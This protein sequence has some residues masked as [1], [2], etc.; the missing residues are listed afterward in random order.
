MKIN[1][2]FDY[3]FIC[4]AVLHEQLEALGLEYKLNNL[5][6]VEF[7]KK[8]SALEIENVKEAF[9]KYGIEILA[10][11]QNVL[12]ER[13]KDVITELISDPE[14]SR[15]YNV[16]SYLADE[17]NYSYA[18]LSS[19]FSEITYSSIENFIILKKIDLAKHLIIHEDFT[20]TEIAHQ[21]N[22]SSVAH[23]SAQFKKTTGL[24]PSAFQR[25]IKKRQ[26]I[27]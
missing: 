16:S 14:K 7:Q 20:L 22:Y 6:E 23:L 10:N 17:L 9:N 26:E 13:I 3:T 2:K 11:P 21:L 5:G 12:V 25:I 1:I 15:K 19:V 24:T 27:E 4:K 18:H 8:L